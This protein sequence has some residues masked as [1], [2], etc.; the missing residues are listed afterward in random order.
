MELYFNQWYLLYSCHVYKIA[1]SVHFLIIGLAIRQ[2]P[3]I[4]YYGTHLVNTI[5]TQSSVMRLNKFEESV[6]FQN[7][8]RHFYLN[9]VKA[10]ER[11]KKKL[12]DEDSKDSKEEKNTPLSVA[13][14]KL[15]VEMV[16]KSSL[17]ACKR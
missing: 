13:M 15:R 10:T 16:G 14:S 2:S 17:L 6:D 9:R 1:L 3:V 11:F 5:D 4:F 7:E 8:C 12:N